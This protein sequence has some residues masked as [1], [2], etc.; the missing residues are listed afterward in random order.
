MIL[1]RTLLTLFVI[2]A[3]AAPLTPS[4]AA[5]VTPRTHVQ[6]TEVVTEGPSTGTTSNTEAETKA[7]ASRGVLL[8]RFRTTGYSNPHGERSAD[9]S[10]P[11]AAHTASSDWSVI[12]KGTKIMLEDS[13]IVYTIEDTG[14]HGDILDIYY[15][16]VREADAHGL[17]YKNVYLVEE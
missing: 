2:T 10:V 14:V 11:R 4:F 12:P 5:T 16:T 7:S 15:P 6:E 17:Q 3:A 9:G 1:R 8:G 13:D